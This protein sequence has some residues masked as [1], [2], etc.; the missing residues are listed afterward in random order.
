MGMRGRAGVRA[1]LWEPT[2]HRTPGRGLEWKTEP[3]QVSGCVKVNQL[4]RLAFW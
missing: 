3:G 4:Q 1:R 2:D